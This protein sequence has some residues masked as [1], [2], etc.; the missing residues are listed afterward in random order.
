MSTQLVRPERED[1][2]LSR[3]EF[4]ALMEIEAKKLERFARELREGKWET[5]N[6]KENFDR[7]DGRPG[8][9]RATIVIEASRLQA[10]GAGRTVMTDGEESPPTRAHQFEGSWQPHPERGGIEHERYEVT[11]SGC[12]LTIINPTDAYPVDHFPAVEALTPEWM[13][14]MSYPKECAPG[15]VAPPL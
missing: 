6:I 2:P 12:G 7:R 15:E 8:Q 4:L 10:Y 5:Y 3:E 14:L 13:D 9:E 11:C 1:G